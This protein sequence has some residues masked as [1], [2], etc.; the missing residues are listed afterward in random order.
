MTGGF[1]ERKPSLPRAFAED[2]FGDSPTHGGQIRRVMRYFP[3]APGPYVDLSTGISPYPY[4]FTLPG[5]EVFTRL[6]E[7][8]DME[9]LARIAARAYGAPR[10]AM[11]AAG[12][13]TQLMI[14]VLP[15]LLGARDVTILGPTYSGHEHAWRAAGARVRRAV[16]WDGLLSAT[17]REQ[18]VCVLCNPNNPD[19]RVIPVLAQLDLAE[20]CARRGGWLIV[21]ETFADFGGESVIPAL[22]REGLVVLRSFGKSYG[23]PGVRLGFLVASDGTAARMRQ[24]L[25]DWPLGGVALAA[26]SQALAD[27]A[28]LEWT[29]N[30]LQTDM[31]RLEEM[32]AAAGLDPAG[33]T[34]LF[35][36]ARTPLSAPNGAGDLWRF[37]CEQGIVTR[38]FDSESRARDIRF[39]LPRKAGEW[40]RLERALA[41]WS[42]S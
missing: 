8:G 3:E 33:G 34:C 18:P 5:P 14:G 9:G 31:R 6:P 21:D 7:A 30:A 11:I 28:W 16:T 13:G 2:H 15:H 41:E 19:G 12:P 22:P 35:R 27:R 17:T 29:G 20:A 10:E 24:A 23:L 26:G 32:L 36:L 4:P 1:P 37:L 40:E 25:G 42:G 38:V 39:G